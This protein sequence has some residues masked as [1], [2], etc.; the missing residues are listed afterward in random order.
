MRAAVI[1]PFGEGRAWET[2]EFMAGSFAPDGFG[3]VDKAD[4]ALIILI[5][6]G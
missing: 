5:D 1:V 3:A 6:N 2:E 4:G